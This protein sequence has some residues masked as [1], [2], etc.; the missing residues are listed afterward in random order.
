MSILDRW[1]W[2]LNEE[3]NVKNK[4]KP[5][6]QLGLSYHV[7]VGSSGGDRVWNKGNGDGKTQGSFVGIRDK[8]LVF[9]LRA[10][11]HGSTFF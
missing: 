9:V 3:E 2:L 7:L 6:D 8:F 1:L 10:R 11:V 5:G 4:S